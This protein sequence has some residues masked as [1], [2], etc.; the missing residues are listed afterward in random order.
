MNSV[1]VEH[2]LFDGIEVNSCVTLLAP[3]LAGRLFEAA[4]RHVKFEPSRLVV[5]LHDPG[6]RCV[7]EP[8]GLRVVVGDDAGREPVVD[9]VSY[10]E[11]LVEVTDLDDGDDR[12]ENLLLD[13][14]RLGVDVDEHS[15]LDEVTVLRLVVCGDATAGCKR[16]TLFFGDIDVVKRRF[17][18]G[19]AD[20]RP[21]FVVE[22]GADIDILGSVD[23]FVDE[24]VVNVLVA[25]GVRTVHDWPVVANPLFATIS[26]VAAGS[27]EELTNVGF[28]R[29]AP[30][31]RACRCRLPDRT[32]SDR[33]R[34]SW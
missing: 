4:K 1:T 18:F 32:Q 25:D 31:R 16:R 13:D 30:S 22:A 9:V 34:Y 12:P 14:A 2:R 29:R 17:K 8:V 19:G 7:D 21:H 24:L 10:F 6:L 33:L 11:A 5:D 26:A 23:K 28:S 27:A 15:R 20:M 3:S